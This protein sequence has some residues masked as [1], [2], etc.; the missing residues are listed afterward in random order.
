MWYIWVD[1]AWRI[2]LPMIFGI[3]DALVDGAPFSH[4][5]DAGLTVSYD[6]DAGPDGK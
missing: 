4:M 2:G 1:L 3:S 6:V 5:A